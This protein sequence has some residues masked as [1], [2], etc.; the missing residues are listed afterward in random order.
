MGYRVAV[1][2]ATGNVGREMMAI[3]EELEFPQ[4]SDTTDKVMM[5]NEWAIHQVKT[6]ANFATKNKLI[7][8]YMGG[9]NYQIEHHLFPKISHVHY[10]AI[11]KIVKKTSEEFGLKYMEFPKMRHAIFAHFMLLK[12]MGAA[13]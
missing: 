11:S 5:E 12:K 13:A 6:T 9:L 8:W 7:T 1:V 2:G 3:L 10:P 4:P